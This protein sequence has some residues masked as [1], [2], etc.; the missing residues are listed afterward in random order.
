MERARIGM[1]RA[2]VEAA[3]GGPPGWYD[4]P[5]NL[6]DRYVQTRE[7]CDALGQNQWICREASLLVMLEGD[8]V[9]QASIIP[10][11]DSSP[12]LLD[13]IRAFFGL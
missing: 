3:V 12:G 8:R 1:T 5:A 13:S 2:E 6:F 10:C 9:T 7:E 11:N 4:G